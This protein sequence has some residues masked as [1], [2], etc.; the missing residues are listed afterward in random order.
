MEIIIEK[1]SEKY[2][3][4]IMKLEEEWVNENI[5]YGMIQN[6]KDNFLQL[7]KEYFYLGLYKNR[8]IGYIFCEIV[9]KN[10]YNIF[11]IEATFVNVTDLYVAKQYRNNKIGEK[12]LEKIEMVA[13]ANG[14]NHIFL[15][16]AT[17]D[18]E[19]VLKFYKRNGYNI[20]TTLLFKNI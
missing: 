6:S 8:V 14:I 16:T 4:E 10:Q 13:K 1:F 18:T 20:W 5:T 7:N 2:L 17:K 15:S 19:K 3:E 12:L 11:P 9:D